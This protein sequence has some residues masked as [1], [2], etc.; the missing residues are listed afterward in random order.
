MNKELIRANR[1]ALEMQK[2]KLL[3][4]RNDNLEALSYNYKESY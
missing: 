3:L 2:H 4:N 1:C